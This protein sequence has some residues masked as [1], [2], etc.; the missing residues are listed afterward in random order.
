[1]AATICSDSDCFTRTSLAPWA[2]PR[3]QRLDIAG[4]QIDPPG[5]PVLVAALLAEEDDVPVVMHP[6]DPGAEIAVGHLGHRAS[7]LRPPGVDPVD[8]RDPK[9]EDAVDGP[10][11]TQCESRRD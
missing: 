1:M 4:V 10:S 9:I 6:D 5:A 8:R 3:R 2:R 7:P 11:G